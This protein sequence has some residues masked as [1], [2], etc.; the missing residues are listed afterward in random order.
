MKAFTL[1]ETMVV[2]V[3][4]SLLMGAISGFIVWGY[5]IQSYSWDQ[6]QAIEEARKGIEVMVREI[7]SARYGEDGAYVI[8]NT[9]D[10][11]FGFFSDVDR[12]GEIEKVRYFLDGTTLKK[13]VIEPVGIPATYP[14][15]TEKIHTI[16]TYV[17]NLPPIFRYFDKL[18]NELPSPA[19][20]KDTKMMEL[21]L[22]INVNPNRPPQNFEIQSRVQLRNLKKEY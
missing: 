2:I 10:Y 1:I 11:Q 18:G 16:S 7:R 3:I 22:V 20:R 15:S 6:S 8:W 5:R 12:D 4:F 14:S 19:R 9:Q 21:F 17:R 13:G